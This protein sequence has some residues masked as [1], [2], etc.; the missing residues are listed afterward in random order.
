M[1]ERNIISI[2][3]LPQRDGKY[4]INGLIEEIL[5]IDDNATII[6]EKGSNV[7]FLDNCIDKNIEITGLDSS[8][9]NYTILNSYNTKREFN[10]YGE[11]YINEIVLHETLENLNVKLL[12]ENSNCDVKCLV[13]SSNMENKFMQYIDHLK[14]YTKSNISNVGVAI[15]GS[16][17]TFDTTGKV[18]KG[19]NNSKC[20]QLSR[21]IVMDD[22]SSVTTLPI[23]LIDEYDCF[24][25][26]G[27]TIGKMSDEDLFYLMS[28]GLSKKEAFL[29]ILQ[30]I[31]N[32]FIS[33]IQIDGLKNEIAKQVSNMIEM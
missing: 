6:I 20:A 30:G 21:G 1:S 28:R 7:S 23:L 3:N 9:I 11:L 5:L 4:Y 17:I 22:I 27:A 13:I 24:A 19:M 16:K 32:P 10:I 31:I 8:V 26:H 25:N 14:P 2:S 18:E 12:N 33:A 29:L 15:N